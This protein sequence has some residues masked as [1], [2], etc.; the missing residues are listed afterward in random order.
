MNMQSLRRSDLMSRKRNFRMAVPNARLEQKSVVALNGLIQDLR[1]VL[2]QQP[3]RPRPP[4]RPQQPRRPQPPLPQPQ[5]RRLHL[6]EPSAAIFHWRSASIVVSQVSQRMSASLLVA[7]SNRA[8][9]SKTKRKFLLASKRKHQQKNALLMLSQTLWRG[10][11]AGRLSSMWPTHAPKKNAG[12]NA[13]MM[14]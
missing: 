13:V 8:S 1:R 14:G 6:H 12:C 4:Q 10:R 5:R 11:S 3:P 9:S 7:V 2:R